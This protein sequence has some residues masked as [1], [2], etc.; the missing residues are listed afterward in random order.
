MTFILLKK[1]HRKNCER[2][3]KINETII[4]GIINFVLMLK[5][6]KRKNRR[7]LKFKLKPLFWQLQLQFTILF[8]SFEV[9]LDI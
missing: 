5:F 7:V 4:F 6:S 2:R 9:Y 3:G 8:D 1:S